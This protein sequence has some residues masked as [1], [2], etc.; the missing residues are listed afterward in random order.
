MQET[1]AANV[2]EDTVTLEFQRS[3]GTLVTQLID[4]RNVR[5]V[6]VFLFGRRGGPNVSFVGEMVVRQRWFWGTGGEDVF[7]APEP[8]LLPYLNR[9]ER[10][11][12][13][14]TE[15]FWKFSHQRLHRGESPK[16]LDFHPR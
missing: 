1:I 13:Q 4:F 11:V 12:V 9:L 10:P 3:D 14:E 16:K 15:I 2:S 8:V 7:S 5:M 6:S